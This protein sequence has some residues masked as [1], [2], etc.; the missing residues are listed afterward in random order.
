MLTTHNDTF[1]PRQLI[2]VYLLAFRM[3]NICF[4][5][6]GANSKFVYYTVESKI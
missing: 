3:T 4:T 5:L 2:V 1:P 6:I